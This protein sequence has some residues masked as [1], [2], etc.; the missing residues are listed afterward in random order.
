MP[1]TPSFSVGM[2]IRDHQ[3]ALIRGRTSRTAGVLSAFE[4]KVWGVREALQRLLIL[5]VKDV[6]IECD[7][8]LTVTALHKESVFH[9]EVFILQ[10]YFGLIS[11]SVM[12]GS[13]PIQSLIP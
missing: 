9:L 8:S 11:Q 1:G 7:S 3:G 13:K 5:Q 2:V 12:L 4:A 6:E 10:D